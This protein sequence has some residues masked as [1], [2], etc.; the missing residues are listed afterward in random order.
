MTETNRAV[1]LDP[2]LVPTTTE[3]VQMY[4]ERGGRLNTDPSIGY[5]PIARYDDLI[6]S[7][8][9]L[10]MS[11]NPTFESIFADV[12]LQRVDTL[13]NAIKSFI[14]ITGLLAQESTP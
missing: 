8:E 14:Q 12:I 1:Q 3:V 13:V 9:Y 11:Q 5:D 7:R 4:E 10:F 6:E 2:H